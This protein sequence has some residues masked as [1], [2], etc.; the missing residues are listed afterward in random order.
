M[1]K[2]LSKA[3]AIML[4]AILVGFNCITTGVYAANIIEQ[5]NE[6]SEENIT[7]D[8]KLGN[9]SSHEGYEYTADIDSTDTNLYLN[10][11][12]KNTGYLKNI[13]INLENSNFKI[14]YSKVNNDQIKNITDYTVELNQIA[15]NRTVEL[16]IPII[17]TM[18]DSIA[19]DELG[20]D[21]TIKFLATYINEDNKEKSIEKDMTVH[22][23]WTT[24]EENL[25]GELS[26][27]VIRYLNYDGKTM[28]SFLLND[29]LKDSKLPVSSKQIQ[30]KVP[31]VNSLNPEEVIVTAIDTLATN[32]KADGVNFTTDNYT[33]DSQTGMLTINVSNPANEQ[34]MVA[35]N[36]GSQD[37]FVITYIYGTNTN[38]EA[39]DVHTEV[40]TNT[41]LLNG[42]VVT[43]NMET[44]DYSLDSKIGDIATVEVV[45]QEATI[46]KGYMY[47]NK[48]KQDGQIETEFSE[49]YRINIG[50][51][52]ALN[53]VTVK[54]NGDFLGEVNA[55][56]Y[57]YNK[58]LSVSSEELVK[59]LGEDGKIDVVKA[60]GTVIGTL[61]KDV[62]ELEINDSNI[63]FVASKPQTE[64]EINLNVT[65]AIRGNLEYSK[66]Q[67]ASFKTLS[68]RVQINGEAVGEIALEEPTS[69][70]NVKLSNTNLSTVVTNENVVMNIELERDDI[71]DNLFANPELNITFPEE[72]TNIEAK[73]AT[74]L[75]EDELVSDA[76]NVNGRTLNLKLNGIQTKY[77]SQST[78]KG[79][80]IRLVLNLTLNNL[81][82]SKQTNILLSY[83]ND[84]DELIKNAS[85]ISTYA[86]GENAN[87]VEVPVNVVAPTGFVTTQSITGYNG[88]ESVT[89]QEEE[90][91]GNLPVL[92]DAK[93]A[94][95]S[96][97]IV[98]NLGSDAEG[99]KVLGRIPF[100]GNKAVDGSADLGS[101][102]DTTLSS[103]LS[104]QN[105]DATV[106]YSTNGEAT[107]DL[108]DTN[109]GWQIEYT[110]DAKSYMIVANNP[111]T[112]TATFN[113]SYNINIPANVDYANIAKASYGVYY[114][115][116]SEE[117]ATQN[118]VLAS[119]VGIKTAEKA[120]LSVNITA[121][122][123]FTGETIPANGSVKEGD[124]I[125]YNI[126]VTNTSNE[127]AENAKA[128]VEFPQGFARL[129]VKDLEIPD[130][131]LQYDK[132]YSSPYDLDLGTINA[133]ETKN[134]SVDLVAGNIITEGEQERTL[135][136]TVTADK[137][138]GEAVGIL[139]TKL[140]KGYVS[141]ILTV[142]YENRNVD[143][144][145][146]LEY[147]IKIE[148]T[149]TEDKSNV[150]AKLILPEGLE[151]ISSGTA[152]GEYEGQYN[153]K[154]REI[155]FDIG[156][157]QG[158]KNIYINIK[159]KVTENAVETLQT[160]AYISCDGIDKNF[161]TNMVNVYYGKPKI[162]ATLSSN[163]TQ[164]NLLDSDTIEYYIDVKNIGSIPARVMIT[165]TTPEGLL[166]KSYSL[167]VSNGQKV[168][169]KEFN[170]S[171]VAETVELEANGS[172]RLIIVAKPVAISSGET[173]EVTVTPQIQLLK[174]YT[175]EAK[176]NISINSLTHTI[177]GTGGTNTPGVQGSYRIAGTAWLDNNKNG[178]KDTDEPR[179]SNINLELYDMQG[180]IVKDSNGI[181]VKAT[182]NEDGQYSFENLNSGDYQIVAYINSE[183]YM[184]TT[185]HI[186]GA[187]DSENSDFVDA[188]I[189][190]TPIVATDILNLSNYN[191]YNVDLGLQEREDFD[192]KLDKIVSKVTVTNTMLE[193]K[194]NEYNSNFAMVSLYN[195][196]IEYSTVLVEYNITIT[197]EGK[198]AGY[199]EEIIDYIPEGMAFS[200]D[201]NPNWYVGADGNLYTTS[202]ANTII[203]P[204]ES[205][206][207]TLTLT[208]RMTGENVGTVVNT[209]EISKTYNEYG[210]EDGD[211]TPGNRKDGEDDISTATVLLAMSTGREIAS[212]IGI[213][214]GV[215]AIIGLAVFVI[216]KYIIKR[217]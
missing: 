124:Y 5:N 198:V 156:N 213:T 183:N 115:N 180:Y 167:E 25:V 69:K 49:K 68:T 121:K 107:A 42:Q 84:N 80:V 31:T 144:D 189:N 197:N 6:T 4:I 177:Q 101:T 169:K 39:I 186:D 155:C 86:E 73:D 192:L 120:E 216:K 139:T 46:N 103:A 71:T 64:G 72:V 100:K 202:L 178:I 205:K 70:V 74:L 92:S 21:S 152:N 131:P 182:T 18:N 44:K 29:G 206:V 50:L 66:E 195:T 55:S 91:L 207:I 14:D 193:P 62:V 148:N 212:F 78:S 57:I 27:D 211:S 161:E 171:Y 165:N 63:S 142:T 59:V 56:N 104:V 129:V 7:F 166:N 194:T 137:M 135:R 172:A 2:I 9:E 77:S 145:T 208:R 151:Y 3:I 210:L 184:V 125:T 168:D 185:Y 61:N 90:K 163:I 19:I 54:E 133:G 123:K 154:T 191:L 28:L 99:L 79:T 89:A 95:I 181:E 153:E 37:R 127:T 30:V 105:L 138:D 32:G 60:D 106:Y 8:V 76:L 111:V 47:S 34:G 187:V 24:A 67:I 17:P 119:P 35:W 65:K 36:K 157:L 136:T 10:I 12:V 15:T 41:T 215:I 58:K 113:F 126:A 146:T 158:N 13:A 98:N 52:E 204:G 97:T 88:D 174:Q 102:F 93:T 214:V 147:T 141:G 11:G 201:L 134:V 83:T 48:D 45:P 116:N 199:A 118:V 122:N 170:S 43:A 176:E 173:K 132:E 190:G 110:Q 143:T 162:E 81:A 179:L 150:I 128:S 96:G 85:G 164:G 87:T 112:N 130:W 82:P 26:Q 23:N 200:S 22:L 159:A 140:V 16:V 203:N 51:A 1:Q 160:K 209:A 38:E 217:I 117:G 33:Y 75:Y 114:N 149:N 108:E 53:E 109:N 40:T 196:Y 20:K 175:E 188:T 94:T